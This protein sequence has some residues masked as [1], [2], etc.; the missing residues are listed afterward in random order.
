M[1]FLV[2]CIVF[3]TLN[4]YVIQY[5]ETG[6]VKSFC[7]PELELFG[8]CSDFLSEWKS[9]QTQ[10]ASTWKKQSMFS[11]LMKFTSGKVFEVLIHEASQKVYVNMANAIKAS[12]KVLATGAFD[13][14]SLSLVNQTFNDFYPTASVSLQQ[15]LLALRTFVSCTHIALKSSSSS[16]PKTSSFLGVHQIRVPRWCLDVLFGPVVCTQAIIEAGYVDAAVSIGWQKFLNQAVTPLFPALQSTTQYPE[17]ESPLV[18]SLL[19][20]MIDSLKSQS[21]PSLETDLVKPFFNEEVPWTAI[22][23]AMRELRCSSVIECRGTSIALKTAMHVKETFWREVTSFGPQ[24]ECAVVFVPDEC[25]F[26][27]QEMIPISSFTR[28]W[29][30]KESTYTYFENLIDELAAITG[31][32]FISVA[33]ALQECRGSVVEAIA[34][35]LDYR[36]VPVVKQPGQCDL[37]V[38]GDLCVSSSS[39]HV[40]KCPHCDFSICMSC[41]WFLCDSSKRLPPGNLTDRLE[42]IQKSETDVDKESV[43][44]FQALYCCPNPMCSMLL[45]PPFWES[46]ISTAT[47]DDQRSTKKMLMARSI[48]RRARHIGNPFAN[49]GMITCT[50]PNC[51]RVLTVSSRYEM[52]HFLFCFMR[53]MCHSLFRSFVPAVKQTAVHF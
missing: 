9:F 14:N 44:D 23:V 53:L 50:R 19:Y 42:S 49:T 29:P 27:I 24:F 28:I 41:L 39:I 32:N 33:H 15:L 1:L 40:L 36:T 7:I 8:L 6:E 45:P 51:G 35:L 22:A 47:H 18:L 4:R 46:M 10:H 21:A 25:I 16:C 34:M 48:S 11:K 31:S 3:D 52:V 20:R 2:F 5:D 26:S 38:S 17:I 30:N 12:A 43:T 37:M 13:E